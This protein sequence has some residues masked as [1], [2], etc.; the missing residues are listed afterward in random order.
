MIRKILS[1]PTLALCFTLCTALFA[2]CGEKIEGFVTEVRWSNVKNPE[3]GEYI[4]IRLKAE[5][6]TFTTVGDH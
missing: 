2:G 5:G 3:Y 6:E 4:N 1:L